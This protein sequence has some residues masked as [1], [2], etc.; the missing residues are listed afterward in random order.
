[1]IDYVLMMLWLAVKAI[2]MAGELIGVIVVIFFI[3]SYAEHK[4]AKFLERFNGRN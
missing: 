4:L 3:V 1:M 2:A